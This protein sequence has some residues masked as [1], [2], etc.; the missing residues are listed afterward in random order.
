LL[1][2]EDLV[3]FFERALK[4]IAL[5]VGPCSTGLRAGSGTFGPIAAGATR[6]FALRARALALRTAAL[7]AAA[8]ATRALSA[9]RPRALALLTREA[10]ARA[11]LF[12]GATAANSFRP[13]REARLTTLRSG[14]PARGPLRAG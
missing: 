2:A 1:L 9:R 13:T 8:R 14:E 4:F 7:C 6:A 3:E 12:A 11:G 10:V 5:A